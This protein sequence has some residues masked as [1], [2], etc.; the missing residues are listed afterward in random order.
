MGEA[1]LSNSKHVDYVKGKLREIKS[2]K[3]LEVREAAR[4]PATVNIPSSLLN[5]T[6]SSIFP[7]ALL[8]PAKVLE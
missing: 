5:H 1:W 7:V 2:D 6:A 8:F 3:E 4:R